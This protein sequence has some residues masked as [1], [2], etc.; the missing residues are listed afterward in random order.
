MKRSI[1]AD[2]L[3]VLVLLPLVMFIHGCSS[4]G[5]E[6]TTVTGKVTYQGSPV[7]MGAIYFHGEGN[8]VA[9]GNI[10][11]DGGFTATDVPV[12]EVRVSLQVR[13][14]G[15]YGQQLKKD[16]NPK[17]KSNRPNTNSVTSV[18]TKYADPTTSGLKYLIE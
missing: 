13:D 5:R 1:R 2:R 3:L 11:Q 14:P 6:T 15:A 16:G 7:S 12:G 4:K 8:Q 18:P 17:E 9:M 10:Q